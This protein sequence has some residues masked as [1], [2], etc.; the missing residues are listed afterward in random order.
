[1][2][3][4]NLG[5]EGKVG[6]WAIYHYMPPYPIGYAQIVSIV[7]ERKGGEYELSDPWLKIWDK[8]Y[9]ST[10]ETKEECEEEYLK[11]TNNKNNYAYEG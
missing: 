1:M 9:C 6:D 4:K 3:T 2:P 7:S 5:R 10:F 11:F 8:R